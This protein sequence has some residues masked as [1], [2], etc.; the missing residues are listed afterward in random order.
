MR[1]RK[2]LTGFVQC[3]AIGLALLLLLS[4]RCPGI[5]SA[6]RSTIYVPDD[7]SSIQ[8]AV[9][10]ASA[11]DTVLVRPGV[12]IENIDVDKS[13]TIQSEG[14]PET[15]RVHAADPYDH[16]FEVLAS[17]VAIS[18]FD[19]GN[20]SHGY[21]IN[22]AVATDSIWIS[23][24]RLH[25]NSSGISLWNSNGN[26]IT[27]NDV[28]ENIGNGIHLWQSSSNLLQ[29]NTVSSNGYMGIWVRD[30]S[31]D[32]FVLSNTVSNN[33]SYGISVEGSRNTVSDNH[34]ASN[35]FGISLWKGSGHTVTGNSMVDDGLVLVGPDIADYL[36]NI[37]P[38]NTVNGKPLYY[39]RDRAGGEVPPGAGQVIVVNSTDVTI[40]NQDV[41]NG[42][43]GIVLAYSSGC[44]VT[45]NIANSNDGSAIVLNHS[46][47]NVVS[48]NEANDS[49][50]ATG[51]ALEHSHQNRVAGN[52]ANENAYYGI[53]L[54]YSTANVLDG[55]TTNSSQ[56]NAGIWLNHSTDNVLTRNV[57]RYNWA[58][59]GIWLMMS[60]N[61]TIYL[62]DFADNKYNA[63]TSGSNLWNSPQHVTYLYHGNV[64]TNFLGNYWGDYA[65]V[66]GDGDGIGDTPYTMIRDEDSHPLMEPFENYGAIES[67]WPMFLHDPQHTGRSP[68]VGPGEPDVRWA[69]NY[70]QADEPAR[71]VA[72]AENGTIYLT[73]TARLYAI[74]PAGMLL[75]IYEPSTG[76]VY[77]VPA[78]DSE[79]VVHISSGDGIVAI[80]P[81]GA[82]KWQVAV[83]YFGAQPVI[84]SRDILYYAGGCFLP[85]E[86]VHPC[87]IAIDR[88]GAVSWVYDISGRI[89]YER[90]SFSLAP[91]G[92][93]G[94]GSAGG[95]TSPTLG[96]D[97]MI[98][99]G[100]EQTL[101]A[102]DSNGTEQWRE[103]LDVARVLHPNIGTASIGN[104]GTIYVPVEGTREDPYARGMTGSLFAIGSNGVVKWE[105]R[106][107]YG[108]RAPLVGPDGSLYYS[109][110]Y[111]PFD[112]PVFCVVALE[113]NGSP[114]WHVSSADQ[115]G[116][117]AVDAEGTLYLRR[118]RA[119][120]TL[121]PDGSEKWSSYPYGEPAQLA[122][123]V[124]GR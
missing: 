87:L 123:G 83:R 8:E 61:N 85:D 27:D 24:N 28:S 26:T 54:A 106:V 60:N 114:K 47:N 112:H 91:E 53:I 35:G 108:I 68:Y 102:I 43:M 39:W 9:D 122:L 119:L 82:L 104:D 100:W 50:S 44:S 76:R 81:N 17:N 95:P 45:D 107:G 84:D 99:I 110:I 96:P 14:G 80:G 2:W 98:Y 33:H 109:F 105:K 93:L 32:N 115:L 57:S 62:N 55:N 116:L 117:R 113:G 75:W 25:H 20:A 77:G 111:Y 15:T 58:S 74:S 73:T 3:L 79:G 118:G 72:V 88:G 121:N 70:W 71:G 66:D 19:I 86:Q 41:S 22:V 12:Y 7:Y 42:S 63:A 46:D 59:A 36:H 49:R 37:D 21:G 120:W 13:L 30:S 78:V 48:T 101:C 51:I 64:Y 5:V 4:V 97:G 38:T 29:G 67:P 34:V 40:S 6:S 92:V 124:D 65:G 1:K 52:S 56:K 18:G 23:D 10:G 11:G 16:V 94:I 31:N 89:T 90:P 69:F 103:T